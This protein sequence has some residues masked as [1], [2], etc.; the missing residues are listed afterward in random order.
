VGVT[1]A[2]VLELTDR[3]Q[4]AIDAG[5]WSAAREAE[6]RRRAALEQ[7]VAEQ[8]ASGEFATALAQLQERNQRMIGE[9]HHHRR[10]VLRDASTVK[11]GQSAAS[12]YASAQA[13]LG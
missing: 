5:D 4:A 3:V 8:G 13:K 7:L 10:R 6:T 1:L 2:E 12:A 9:V 11:T